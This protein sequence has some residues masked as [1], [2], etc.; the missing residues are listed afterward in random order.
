MNVIETRQFANVRKK[1]H[2]NQRE[3]L[4]KAVKDLINNPSLGVEKKGDLF[5]FRV[6]KFKML[7]QLM[8]LGYYF[9]NK[10]IVL[11]L[12]FVGLHE[13]FYRDIKRLI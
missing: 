8:L 5:E 9:N 7:D 6:Y 10:Q 11:T 4:E 13:N 3:A 1:L 2:Q 12:I